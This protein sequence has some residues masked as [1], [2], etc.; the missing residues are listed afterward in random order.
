MLRDRNGSTQYVRQPSVSC[1]WTDHTAVAHQTSNSP[2][3]ALPPVWSGGELGTTLPPYSAP[4]Y[5]SFMHP[6]SNQSQKHTHDCG[7]KVT[8]HQSSGKQFLCIQSQPVANEGIIQTAQ[9]HLTAVPPGWSGGE[10]G[11]ALPPYSTPT[12]PSFSRYRMICCAAS[13]GVTSVVSITM[14]ASSGGSY[15]SETPVNSLMMPARALA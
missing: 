2:A 11:T 1:E 12:Y 15:G 6:V 14:S 10:L 3:N 5:P 7:P 8:P 4:T 13:S 9:D